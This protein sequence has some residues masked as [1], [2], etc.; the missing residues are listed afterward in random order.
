[1]LDND[2]T[3]PMECADCGKECQGI[4]GIRGHRR[5]CPGRKHVVH[6]QRREPQEPL[7][8]PGKPL[9]HAPNQ[10]ITVQESGSRLNAD[11]V[12][13]V[14]CLHEELQALRLDLVHALPIRR[15]MATG[16]QPEGSPD[17][18]DW[19]ELA[20]DVLHLEQ[21]TD[22]IVTQARITRDDPWTLHKVALSARDRSVSWRREEAFYSWQMNGEAIGKD[23][24]DMLTKFGVPELE[25][26]WTR[27]IERFRWLT[28][29]TKAT[30]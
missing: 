21:A 16:P 18:A 14:L 1:M 24:E 3:E 6:N 4:Q 20:K 26:S 25:A 23:L 15:L 27:V 11:A 17:Y 19:Y 13:M 8:E 2:I 5:S 7:V 28:S 29:H 22:R 30:L 12:D 9:V 10:Q